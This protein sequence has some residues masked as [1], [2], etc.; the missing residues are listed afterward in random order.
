MQQL[1]TT[2]LPHI[3]IQ[4]IYVNRDNVTV[5][6]Y[7]TTN[8]NSTSPFWMEEKYFSDF[9]NVH[10]MLVHDGSDFASKLSDPKSRAANVMTVTVNGER[11]LVTDWMYQLR[12]TYDM[13]T[14]TLTEAV[15]R[16]SENVVSNSGIGNSESHRASNLKD[17]A[18]SVE[19][20]I[21]KFNLNSSD[22]NTLKLYAFSHL[23]VA[24]LE[25]EFGLSTME[26]SILRLLEIGGNFKEDLVLQKIENQ[27]RVPETID[28]LTFEDGTPFNGSYHY[29]GDSNPGP[30]GYI[31]WMEGPAAPHMLSNARTLKTK[32]IAYS[33]VVAN[34]LFD[35]R[36]FISE[37]NGSAEELDALEN[38]YNSPWVQ[39][40]STFDSIFQSDN[41]YNPDTF[42]KVY[43]PEFQ[44]DL[45]S[46]TFEQ[47][48]R[49]T[50]FDVVYNAEHY[51]DVHT[52]GASHAL[53]F[54]INYEKLI[55]IKSK[56]PFF[57]KRMQQEF[58]ITKQ[59]ILNMAKIRRI[60][61]SRY[62]LSNSPRS[63]NP[64]CT[65]DYD[66]YDADE[67][68]KIIAVTSQEDEQVLVTPVIGDDGRY[69]FLELES[70]EPGVKK[71]KLKDRDLAKNV[72]FGK[73]AYRV[74][75][76]IDDSIKRLII[77]MLEDLRNY[78]KEYQRFLYEGP[79]NLKFAS[80][81]Y[82]DEFVRRARREYSTVITALINQF[83]S[84]HG[85]LGNLEYQNRQTLRNELQRS[86]QPETGDIQTSTKFADHCQDLIRTYAEILKKDNVL[87]AAG[88]NTSV[89]AQSIVKLGN[90]HPTNQRSN[91]I[92]FSRRIPGHTEAYVS[93]DL[94]VSYGLSDIL[95]MR[96]EQLNAADQAARGMTSIEGTTGIWAVP[97]AVQYAS[98]DE[99]IVDVFRRDQ[100]ARSSEFEHMNWTS[101]LDNIARTPV[102]HT[103][104]QIKDLI[105]N[106][107]TSLPTHGYSGLSHMDPDASSFREFPAD[108]N[109][110]A[111]FF[112]S[113][114]DKTGLTET[115]EKAIVDSSD[116][117][118]TTKSFN[119]DK[120]TNKKNLN[121]YYKKS[122]YQKM[123]DKI[124]KALKKE[125]GSES[126]DFFKE[127]KSK[128]MMKSGKSSQA[129][130]VE[131][132]KEN[133]RKHKGKKVK[134]KVESEGSKSSG[135][136]YKATNTTAEV[137]VEELS[138]V[139]NAPSNNTVTSATAV[140]LGPTTYN[141]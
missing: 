83:V 18:F 15:N 76:S 133:L 104:E 125:K 59:E 54:E 112:K 34:F 4:K 16:D 53:E 135:E 7:L 108:I 75:I 121:D 137:S 41:G 58:G 38:N 118:D 50:P 11:I 139:L 102:E 57:I 31:G 117:F 115:N 26:D 88:G 120:E 77:G 32:T 128:L 81:A 78:L 93:G 1:S 20:P 119:K 42:I 107:I 28:I 101:R 23:D 21:N 40:K 123:E 68:D 52:N 94:F 27:L 63:N 49:H 13:T 85:L 86:I 129:Q 46:K 70:D 60:A 55:R 39:T 48:S 98:T 99:E 67:I 6:A 103:E 56:F 73:Y 22:L 114:E 110:S 64:V 127:K 17:I 122:I 10:F 8:D 91:S 134:I 82:T 97:S 113:K 36:L 24:R 14:I 33:K 124:S 138:K 132:N 111:T 130:Y 141:L 79:S 2:P 100:W 29:H 47:Q 25:Q 84:M 89:A 131:V 61:I 96:L 80:T 9:I 74:D 105:N 45:I 126:P 3:T 69:V 12:N 44:Q 92:E 87:Q 140:N 106:T 19:I 5:N 136:K 109:T 43:D 65:A 90:V 95:D 35:D 72:N 51:L 62:R 66:V 30:D 116:V 37:Y 71:F